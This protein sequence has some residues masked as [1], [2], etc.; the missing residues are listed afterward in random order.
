MIDISA[1]GV[2]QPMLLQTRVWVVG[3]CMSSFT[4]CLADEA[5]SS[6]F[7]SEITRK[8]RKL[9]FDQEFRNGISIK[10]VASIPP[11]SASFPRVRVYAR[12]SRLV[13]IYHASHLL[14]QQS[15]AHLFPL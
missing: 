14:I 10:M 2:N 3:R 7:H 9:H 13:W 4:F 11:I 1:D 15:N 12:G 5:F 8:L 6:I